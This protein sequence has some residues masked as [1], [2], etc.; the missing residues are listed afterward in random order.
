MSELTDNQLD[1]LY[2]MSEIHFKWFQIYCPD[3]KYEEVLQLN[4]IKMMSII[5]GCSDCSEDM[6]DFIFDAI[7]RDYKE[8]LNDYKP[9]L[10]DII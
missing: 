9:G 10:D 5:D 6:L 2:E 4:H 8:M 3:T 7:I 1:K